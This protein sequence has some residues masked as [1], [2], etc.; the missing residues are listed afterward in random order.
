[1]RLTAEDRRILRYNTQFLPEILEAQSRDIDPKTISESNTT[2]YIIGSGAHPSMNMEPELS[3][4]I[5][6][7]AN[8]KLDLPAP[9]LFRCGVSREAVKQMNAGFHDLPSHNANFLSTLHVNG[10]T[11]KHVG[12]SGAV[13]HDNILELNSAS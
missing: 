1:M 4:T 11:F 13:A 8:I 9:V 10:Y 5:R 2:N 12:K 6:N 7:K 3:S